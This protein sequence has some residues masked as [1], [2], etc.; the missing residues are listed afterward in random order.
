[1]EARRWRG[2]GGTG[3]GFSQKERRKGEGGWVME[4][5]SDRG[6]ILLSILRCLQRP[7]KGSVSQCEAGPLSP[8]AAP[9]PPGSTSTLSTLLFPLCC[10][11]HK[12]TLYDAA[13]VVNKPPTFGPKKLCI[14]EWR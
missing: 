1:M 8:P 14:F 11:P 7:F 4:G 9:P 3:A 5:E 6:V 13:V 12:Q 2:G 10:S